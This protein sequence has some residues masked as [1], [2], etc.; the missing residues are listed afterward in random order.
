MLVD[1]PSK[2]ITALT[3]NL[4]LYFMTNL[5]REPG[6]FFLFFLISFTTTMVMSMIFRTIGSSTRTLSQAMPGASLMSARPLVPS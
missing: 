6:A 2:I 5:R 3:I 4:I 1:M